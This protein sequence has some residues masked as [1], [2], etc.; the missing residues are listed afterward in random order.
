MKRLPKS[1]KQLAKRK[2]TETEQAQRDNDE[3]REKQWQ[4]GREKMA[5]GGGYRM[6]R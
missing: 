5:K 6:M 3:A 4:Q 1:P 2:L